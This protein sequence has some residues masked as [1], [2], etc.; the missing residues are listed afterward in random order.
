MMN[1]EGLIQVRTLNEG[2]ELTW[3]LE[4]EVAIVRNGRDVYRGTEHHYVDLETKVGEQVAYHLT[5]ESGEEAKVYTA[6]VNPE[7][8]VYWNRHMTAA[9]VTEAGTYLH[10]DPI[11][12]VETYTIYRQ[13]RRVAEVSGA[14]Y[15][16][17]TPL[18]EPTFYEVRALRPMK[19][20]GKPGSHLIDFVGKA[21]TLV[22]E[23]TLA[24]RR[25]S[26]LYVMYFMVNPSAPEIKEVDDIHLRVQPFIKQPILKNPNLFSPH[27]YFEGDGRSYNVYSEDYRTRTEVLVEQ[28]NDEP[29][30]SIKKDANVTRGYTK[31]HKVTGE[32]V[33]SVDK[34]Y[35]K[36]VTIEPGEVAYRLQHSVGNPLVVAPDIKYTIVAHLKNRATFKLSGE[37]TQAPHHEIYMRIGD[38]PWITIHRADSLGVSFMAKPFPYCHWTYLTCMQ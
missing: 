37:H 1:G 2:I 8:E 17:E 33:A 38:A 14:G 3:S 10:W 19:R 24:T 12:D 28:L 22:K 16:D 9:V 27:T 34:V 36:D 20:T 25:D 35:L 31:N 26:E 11:S 6:A 7:D 32:D 15:I 23:Q 4:G 30:V 29:L 5:F 13:G 21:M 18:T